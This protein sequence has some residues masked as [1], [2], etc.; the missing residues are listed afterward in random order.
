MNL[1]FTSNINQGGKK[2][3]ISFE[4]KVTM[5]QYNI[6]K[7][8][9]FIDPK[10]NVLN[11]IEVAKDEVNIFM[12]TSSLNMVMK[13]SIE[14]SYNT[15]HGEIFLT[16]YLTK[17]AQSKNIVEFTYN[18]KSNNKIIGKYSLKLETGEV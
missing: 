14:A 8:F 18:L 1:K 15:P 9:E 11:R 3:V 10:T 16:T 7:V 4:T 6:F 2:S 5:S 12:G 17:L 13:T